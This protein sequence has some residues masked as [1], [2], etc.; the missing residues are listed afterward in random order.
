MPQLHCSG[1]SWLPHYF[2]QSRS[3]LAGASSF[4]KWDFGEE[5][6][7]V[8][9]LV[10]RL[11]DVLVIEELEPDIGGPTKRACL[12]DTPGWQLFFQ[13]QLLIIPF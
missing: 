3:S 13:E 10:S 2:S 6:V 8:Q 7:A 4:G 9:T 11:L 12:G 5:F 1:A